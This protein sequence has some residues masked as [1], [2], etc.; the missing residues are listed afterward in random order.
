MVMSRHIYITWQLS[1]LL[2]W[3][4]RA[5]SYTNPTGLPGKRR[6]RKRRTRKGIRRRRRRQERRKRKKRGKKKISEPL[7]KTRDYYECCLPRG[8]MKEHNREFFYQ[9]TVA[10]LILTKAHDSSRANQIT[11]KSQ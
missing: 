1:C 5:I 9:M 7:S 8:L 11:Q 2:L 4:C 10:S 3:V 6:R